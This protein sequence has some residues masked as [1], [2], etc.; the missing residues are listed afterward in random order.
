M[1]IQ[2]IE[3]ARR[4]STILGELN[5]CG[6]M[7]N[8][9]AKDDETVCKLGCLAR[10]YHHASRCLFFPQRG[11]ELGRGLFPVWGEVIV[12]CSSIHGK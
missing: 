1:Q 9:P 5:P 6:R 2:Q 4:R 7:K 11:E 3:T 10:I 8:D 12:D